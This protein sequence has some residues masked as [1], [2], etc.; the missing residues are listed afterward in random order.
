MPRREHDIELAL[1]SLADRLDLPD[2]PDIATTVRSHLNAYPT[3]EKQEWFTTRPSWRPVLSVAA[4]ILVLAVA[5]MVFSPATRDAVADWIG[6]D[7]VRITHV[8]EPTERVGT[9][10]ALGDAITL[11]EAEAR[12]SFPVRAPTLLGPPEEIYAS[13]QKEDARLSFVYRAGTDLPAADGLEVGALFEQFQATIERDVLSKQIFGGADV[14][15]VRVEGADG[16]W[17]S[18]GPHQVTYLDPDGI[19][20]QDQQRLAGNTLL[21]EVDGV[22]YRLE[23]DI[24][25]ARALVIARSLS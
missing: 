17:L 14:R 18:G 16:Y 20:T 1:T 19:P 12:V 9:D 22:V 25:L 23:A 4:S 5:L 7:G 15:A 21:W 3:P 8:P 2:G 10:L 13:G 6:L 24:P 11:E